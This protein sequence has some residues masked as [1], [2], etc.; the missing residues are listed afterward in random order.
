M[1]QN[2]KLMAKL[3]NFQCDPCGEI[4]IQNI[5][6]VLKETDQKPVFR[7]KTYE[8]PVAEIEGKELKGDPENFS[9]W[10]YPDIRKVYTLAEVIAEMEEEIRTSKEP[11]TLTDSFEGIPKSVLISVLERFKEKDPACGF[12]PEPGRPG[13]WVELKAGD[14]AYN[15]NGEQIWPAQNNKPQP[16]FKP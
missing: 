15:P 11:D 7:F 16:R 3:Y 12:I 14:K 4:E 9:G 5:D 8:L 2:K 10:H 6:D 1:S 13:D